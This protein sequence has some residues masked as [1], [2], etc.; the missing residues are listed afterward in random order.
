MTT[1]EGQTVKPD[2]DERALAHIERRQNH[3]S[4]EVSVAWLEAPEGAQLLL[5]ANENFCTAAERKIVLSFTSGSCPY[6]HRH[7]R[8]SRRNPYPR[9]EERLLQPGDIKF[10]PL[11]IQLLA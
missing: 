11:L 9:R 2:L 1:C 6:D 4:V 3:S 7:Y 8:G 10:Y 5:V